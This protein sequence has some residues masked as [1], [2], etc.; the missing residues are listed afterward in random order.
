MKITIEVNNDAELKKVLA[1][2]EAINT[3]YV[4]TPVIL[5]RSITKGNKNIDTEGLFG[6]WKRQP[7]TLEEIRKKH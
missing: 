2:L 3:D 1:A 5:H 6:I 7:R 4:D